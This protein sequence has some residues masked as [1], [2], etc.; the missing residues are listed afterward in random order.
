M[1]AFDRLLA[2]WP[3]HTPRPLLVYIGDGP[4][5]GML[6]ELR[7]TLATADSMRF[8]GYQ[9]DVDRWLR[10]ATICVVPSVW[11]DA[12]PLS[13]LEAMALGKPVI[14][15]A[16]GGVPEEI[17]SPEVGVLVPKGDV[18]H[19]ASA[20]RALLQ[21]ET[22]REQVGRAARH[23]IAHELTRDAHLAAIVLHLAPA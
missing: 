6:R 10:A 16:V 4:A 13:V 20:M 14:A 11:E 9:Q 1:R 22:R 17:N 21:D 2:G 23:R 3:D 8:L 7:D 15:S 19:L 18:E 5:M 12:C